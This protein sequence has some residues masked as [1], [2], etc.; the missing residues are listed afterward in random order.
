M[1][2]R[3]VKINFNY[4]TPV[5]EPVKQKLEE[6]KR[7]LEEVLVS[8]AFLEA[9]SSYEKRD[10]YLYNIDNFTVNVRIGG[11]PDNRPFSYNSKESRMS[12]NPGIMMFYSKKINAG[13]IAHEIGHEWDSHEALGYDKQTGEKQFLTA[14]QEDIPKLKLIPFREKLWAWSEFIC[15]KIGHFITAVLG[16][17]FLPIAFALKYWFGVKNIWL[18]N[19][20][21]DG[22]FG[23][24][25][26]KLRK[27]R[28]F[29]IKSRLIRK[30]YLL[31]LWY[32]RNSL[33]NLKLLT[34][35]K[36]DVDDYQIVYTV[37]NEV[38]HP[39]TWVTQEDRGTNFVWFRSHGLL[40]FRY[41]SSGKFNIQAG[42]AGERYN[43]KIRR[44]K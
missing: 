5:T 19:D 31:I 43:F 9:F 38:G 3:N 12:V 14:L 8:D 13:L 28:K 11:A 23:D 25:E 42:A 32:L 29:P 39:M 40:F 7:Y 30:L 10:Q 34:A 33:W 26:W 37:K 17:P 44:V 21:K 4:I 18:L 15:V 35:P 27:L 22:D 36:W 24:P 2:L 20:T 41:S 16:F 1:N 6:A